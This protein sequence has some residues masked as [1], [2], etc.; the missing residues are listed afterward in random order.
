MKRKNEIEGMSGKPPSDPG[1][2][3]LPPLKPKIK[4]TVAPKKAVVSVTDA[5][6]TVLPDPSLPKPE[7]ASVATTSARYEGVQSRVGMF[8]RP[9]GAAGLPAPG[10]RVAEARPRRA[11]NVARPLF[12]GPENTGEEENEAEREEDDGAAAARRVAEEEAPKPPPARLAAALP[13]PPKPELAAL[14]TVA[15]EF[16]GVAV[17]APKK[18]YAESAVKRRFT[19]DIA[20]TL[21]ELDDQLQQME[22]TLSL[23]DKTGFTKQA[24]EV[25]GKSNYVFDDGQRFELRLTSEDVSKIID[26]DICL[27]SYLF[28]FAGTRY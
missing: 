26:G 15:E 25:E 10:K 19:E 11:A 13:P 18:S 17:K 23:T 22:L 2:K 9:A 21:V 16:M 6:L 27:L 5:A 3:P 14:P 1:P 7:D 8:G 24:D 12:G 4:I 28:L 20:K